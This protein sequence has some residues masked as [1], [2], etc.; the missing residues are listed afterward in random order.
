[1]HIAGGQAFNMLILR[2]NIKDIPKGFFEAAEMYGA[3]FSR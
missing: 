1:M 2:N 3:I